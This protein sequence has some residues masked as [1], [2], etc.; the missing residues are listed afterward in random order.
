MER[1]LMVL[2]IGT[3]WFFGA[4]FD[5]AFKSLKEGNILPPKDAAP[6]QS[7]LSKLEEHGEL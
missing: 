6:V 3:A 7:V 4:R 2:Q 1:A 5:L